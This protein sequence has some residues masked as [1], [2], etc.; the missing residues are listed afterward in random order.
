[1][2]HG[3]GGSGFLAGDPLGQVGITAKNG[4]GRRIGWR[5]GILVLTRDHGAGAAAGAGG[6]GEGDGDGA[7]DEDVPR[8]LTLLSVRS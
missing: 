6:G 4:P 7:G 2:R 5:V 8:F 1:V 3:S